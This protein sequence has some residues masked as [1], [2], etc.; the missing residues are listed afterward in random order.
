MRDW[1]TYRYS[2]RDPKYEGD[3]VVDTPVGASQRYLG[4]IEWPA[5]KEIVIA[6]LQRNGAPPELVETL[7][8]DKSNR[9]VSPAAVAQVWWNAA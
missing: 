7:R 5:S 1:V 2:V 3:A 6:A 9:I 4:G 8:A